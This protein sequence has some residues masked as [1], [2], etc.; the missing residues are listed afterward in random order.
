MIINVT[1]LSGEARFE[2]LPSKRH[3][4]LKAFEERIQKRVSY[5]Y[6]AT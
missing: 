5:G 4:N 1:I 6:A 2:Q 3:R